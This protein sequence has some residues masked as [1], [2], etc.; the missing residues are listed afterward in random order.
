[1]LTIPDE[2]SASRI[3]VPTLCGLP[4]LQLSPHTFFRNKAAVDAR[5]PRSH[6]LPF[7]RGGDEEVPGQLLLCGRADPGKKFYTKFGVGRSIWATMHWK[8]QWAQSRACFWKMGVKMENGPLG[9]PADFLIAQDGT[10]VAAKYGTHAYDQWE[11]P[12]LLALANT[13]G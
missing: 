8:A 10:V 5:D 11:V 6:L 9:L 13:T 4:D 2:D 7:V 1:M 3:A 12:E